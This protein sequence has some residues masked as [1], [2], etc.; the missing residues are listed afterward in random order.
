MHRHGP[1]QPVIVLP[2]KE[3]AA[4]DL[5]LVCHFKGLPVVPLLPSLG[6]PSLNVL[7]GE[8]VAT[9]QVS[10]CWSSCRS[11]KRVLL[12]SALQAAP[13]S[14][15]FVQQCCREFLVLHTLQASMASCVSTVVRTASKLQV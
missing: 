8:F 7:A 11:P 12:G 13:H 2:V 9:M 6:K 10:W 14:R 15:H 5:A 3:V 1:G 4:R